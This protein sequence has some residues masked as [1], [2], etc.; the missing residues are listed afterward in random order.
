MTLKQSVSEE[1]A[2]D[3]AMACRFGKKRRKKRGKERERKERRTDMKERA[4]REGKF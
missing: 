3:G 4:G 2:D 1:I